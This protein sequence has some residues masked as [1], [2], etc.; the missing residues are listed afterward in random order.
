MVWWFDRASIHVEY[1][2]KAY[3]TLDLP[4]PV[5]R[6]LRSCIS[7]RITRVIPVS[8]ANDCSLTARTCY[9]LQLV[10]GAVRRFK[11]IALLFEGM[12][13]LVFRR[14]IHYWQD[15]PGSLTTELIERIPLYT[16]ELIRLDGFG[17]LHRFHGAFR[18]P[19]H[20]AMIGL[21]RLKNEI[22]LV[23]SVFVCLLARLVAPPVDRS[24]FDR[25][26]PL[27]T[28]L[29]EIDARLASTQPTR[30]LSITRR[31]RL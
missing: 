2:S 31:R 18:T 5:D 24:T 9:S 4:L 20:L 12:H 14:S 13:G 6:V 3:T 22:R 16:I 26:T 28:Q 17:L 1:C 10:C 11:E 30:S 15:Q 25:E 29:E 21:D 8:A 23:L 19:N 27:K 7:L